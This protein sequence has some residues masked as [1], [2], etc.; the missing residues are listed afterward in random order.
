MNAYINYNILLSKTSKN[1][2]DIPKKKMIEIATKLKEIDFLRKGRY[3]DL[4]SNFK[5]L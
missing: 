5:K 3:D 4:I 2:L 1:L